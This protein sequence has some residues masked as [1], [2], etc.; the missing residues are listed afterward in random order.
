LRIKEI[1][2]L[3]ALAILAVMWHHYMAW[4]KHSG[5]IYGWL[6][7]DMFF[8]ISGFLI[9]GILADLKHSNRLYFSTFYGRR[10]FRV[11][12]A[13]YFLLLLLILYSAIVHH[14]GAFSLWAKY[15]FYY[16]S[17]YLGP[18]NFERYGL[19]TLVVLGLGPLWSLSVE[20]VFYT[21]WAPIIRFVSHRKLL[22]LLPLTIALCPV[23]RWHFHTS[24]HA[25]SFSF[26]C[27]MDAL[28]IGALVA[29]IN[30]SRI[31]SAWVH[32]TDSI[33]DKVCWI[34]GVVTIV[35][36]IF[37]SGNLY[38]RNVA[39]FGMSLADLWFGTIIYTVVRHSNENRF[40]LNKLR[41]PL[42]G[43]IAQVSYSLYLVHYPLLMVSTRIVLH[44]HLNRSTGAIVST[45]LGI[46]LSF[47]AAYAMWYFI[48][49]PP[50]RL[51]EK[52]FP[53]KEAIQAV[54]VG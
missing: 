2:G 25:E 1:D 7:V 39:V 24:E 21:I 14:A 50:L 5:S 4:V 45:L 49:K 37:S 19:D 30:R 51:K 16:S 13:Y 3:R 47:S 10:A 41:S 26:L 36:F 22:V 11:F 35:Y 34:L 54:S 52:M 6:G 44:L 9:T 18:P 38:E 12:P 43:S 27:R 40:F 31:R 20:E 29:L 33:F 28:S 32:K 23:L 8:V 48:E 42:L 53:S 15:L 17:L 46:S